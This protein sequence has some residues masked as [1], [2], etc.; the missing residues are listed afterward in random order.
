VLVVDDNEDAAAMLGELLEALGHE[1]RTAG[2]GPEALAAVAV[3][4]PDVVVLDIGLPGMSGYEVAAKM[5]LD[6][7]LAKVVL[8]ALTGYGQ[9]SD[10]QRT[11]DA[12]FDHHLVK[13]AD[14]AALKKI[15]AGVVARAG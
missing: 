7:A 2:D 15:L 14:F 3:R 9:E 13:P 8:V 1:V 11:R 12:G 10:R 6:P 4:A 5:R